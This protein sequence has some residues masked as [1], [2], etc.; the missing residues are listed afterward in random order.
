VVPVLE[1]LGQ[2]AVGAALAAVGAPARRLRRRSRR[3]LVDVLRDT[4]ELAVVVDTFE[5]RVQRP[6][7][8]TE[9]GTR[10]ADAYSSGKK[11]QHTLK[12]QVAV[13]EE[14]GKIVDVPERVPGPTADL[15]VLRDS[16]LLDRLPP[17]MGGLGD[18]AYVGSATLVPGVPAA[19]PRRKP[20]G[21]P[22]PPED[23][24][25]NTAFARRRIIV[26]HTIGRLRRFQSLSQ[27]DRHHRRGHTRRVR[28]VAGSVN[29]QL[30]RR[31]P[32]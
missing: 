1:Q 26:E 9:D 10:V 22:R 23:V 29:R 4:P 15:T 31:F 21:Q 13:D 12:A 28:A 17:G 24:A 16:R 3:R 32:F 25:Y 27:T 2:T 7:G 5:Q 18:L 6:H 30:A 20:R 11:N 19:T 14:T 8:Y